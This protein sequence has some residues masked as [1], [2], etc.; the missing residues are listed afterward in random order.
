MKT[1]YY[2]VN[3]LFGNEIYH[4]IPFCGLLLKRT[5]QC[6]NKDDLAD[7]CF[8]E[9]AKKVLDTI[10]IFKDPFLLKKNDKIVKVQKRKWLNVYARILV[11]GHKYFYPLLF[12]LSFF[13]LKIFDSSEAAVDY[14]CLLYPGEQ[15][16]K[17]CLPRSIFAATTSKRFSENGC[18][19][20]GA[21][22]PSTNMHAWIIEDSKNAYRRDNDWT[23]YTPIAI[24]K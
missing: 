23:C 5:V 20:I 3:A 15:Q 11:F 19:V 12:G 6:D 18:M 17:L 9:T 24:M 22:L 14:F 21:F 8:N 1:R 16:R 7:A 2:T 4:F 10:E 13:R